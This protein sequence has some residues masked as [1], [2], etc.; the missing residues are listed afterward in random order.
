M[1][2]ITADET[3]EVAAPGLLG[4]GRVT[5]FKVSPDG[6][7]MALIREVDG[8]SQLGLARINRRGN[9]TVDGWQ[10]LDLTQTSKPQLRRLQDLS[11]VDATDLLV[12]G[13]ASKTATLQPF[14]ISQ[15]ASRINSEGE[16]TNWDPVELTVLLGSQAAI[17]V[18][19]NRQTYRDEGNQW[20]PY[21][22]K[23]STIAYP[24]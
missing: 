24:G 14:R 6:A 7:R 19:R 11:W 2:M 4:T 13:A 21:V 10:P 23:V 15:D 1:W 5:A 20:A 3:F 22:D 8:D 17:V 12:L 18:G 16:S 9:V